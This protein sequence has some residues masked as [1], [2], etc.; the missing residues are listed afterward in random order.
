MASLG[1]RRKKERNQCLGRGWGGCLGRPGGYFHRIIHSTFCGLWF[2][3]LRVLPLPSSPFQGSGQAP[4]PGQCTHGPELR[5]ISTQLRKRPGCM[6]R[7]SA[8]RLP[9]R[10]PLQKCLQ[11]RIYLQEGSGLGEGAGAPVATRGRGHCS[12]GSAEHRGNRAGVWD[13][14]SLNRGVQERKGWR[15]V[16]GPELPSCQVQPCPVPGN[17]N[18]GASSD[19]RGNVSEPSSGPGPR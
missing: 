19:G 2:W 13:R 4:R 3:S 18:P 14:I 15:Q 10:R 6:Q 8:R 5:P 7:F 17:P 12:E 11:I 16:P 1:K 9:L